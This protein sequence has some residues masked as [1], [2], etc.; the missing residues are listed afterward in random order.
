MNVL[1]KN[2]G[3]T[4]FIQSR[5]AIILCLLC[6]VAFP[7]LAALLKDA[8]IHCTVS[9]VQR[10]SLSHVVV[11]VT[12]I[13]GMSLV[14]VKRKMCHLWGVCSKFTNFLQSKE[15]TLVET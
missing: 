12:S 13:Y 14:T 10:P 4:T 2:A 1:K 15:E 9:H 3:N 6:A 5:W 8:D 11:P 7:V